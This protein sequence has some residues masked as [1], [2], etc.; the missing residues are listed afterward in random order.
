MHKIISI[1]I[2]VF[3]AMILLQLHGPI[4]MREQKRIDRINL[5]SEHL[6]W[7][8]KRHKYHGTWISICD[9]NGCVTVQNNKQ[10]KL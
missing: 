9:K 6:K 5:T 10:I 3:Y 7:Y 4:G 1:F 8:E 2:L